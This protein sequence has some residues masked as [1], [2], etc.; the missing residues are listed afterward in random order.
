MPLKAGYSYETRQQNIAELVRSGYSGEQAVAIAYSK[1]CEAA[2][3]IS[4]KNRREAVLRRLRK[5]GK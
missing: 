2:K 5:R 4:D 3:N 1:A